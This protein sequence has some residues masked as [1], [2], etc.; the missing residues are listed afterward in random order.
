VPTLT[1]CQNMQAYR[2]SIKKI[3]ERTIKITDPR[4]FEWD[5]M[6]TLLD[7]AMSPSRIQIMKDLKWV[8]DGLSHGK[9]L[10][11]QH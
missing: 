3:Y 5:E 1:T 7:G 10:S 2:P 6:I 11:R 4:N 8:C 9:T